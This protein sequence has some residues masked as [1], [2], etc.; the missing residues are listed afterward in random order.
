MEAK[1]SRSEFLRICAGA[2]ALSATGM[3][4][5]ASAAQV[6]KASHDFHLR[7]Y[8]LREFVHWINEEFEPSVRLVGRPKCYASHPGGTI[9]ALYGVADMVCVLYT[10][11]ALAPSA[12]ELAEWRDAFKVFENPKTGWFREKNSDLAP[13]HNTA[14]A[15][16]AM[17]LLNLSPRYK[18][19]MGREYSDIRG[20]LKSLDWRTN[21][22]RE[23]HKGAGIGSIYTLVRDLRSP[24]WFDSYFST[25]DTF[26]DA[27]NGLMGQG[28][29]AKGDIDQVGGTFHY[30]FLYRYFNR[31]MP[32]PEKRI[33]T[34]LRLQQSDG[35]WSPTNHLWMTLDAIYLMTRTL[36]FCP[37]R[38]G[39]VQASVRKALDAVERDFYSPSGRKTSFAKDDG[40]HSLT[41]AISIAAESQQFLNA[42]VV[43]TDWPL[44]LVLDRRP[45][46]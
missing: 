43:I 20:Y 26:F 9:V 46:I 6:G 37:H 5:V 3:T 42:D 12:G 18:V 25:C 38:L 19:K 27:N 45:F 4:K 14:F 13:E 44:K 29:P 7:A 40:V 8:D 11:G 10:I 28:K 23:S 30:S 21:V 31:R 15:L 36:R 34:V 1:Y 22:Y 24:E 39:D 2:A 35:Y 33:D 16:A 41:A 17:Q 32:Y